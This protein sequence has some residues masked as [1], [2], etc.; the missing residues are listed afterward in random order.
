M[1]ASR[2]L[3]RWHA[4]WASGCCRVPGAQGR[5]RKLVNRSLL[6]APDGDRVARYDKIHLFDVDLPTGERI[7]ESA[8]LCRR[9]L[10][11]RSSRLPWG[12]LGLTICY[13]VRFPSLYRRLP[14]RAQ[15]FFTVPS[16]FTV[17]TGEAHWHVLLQGARDRDR[18]YVLAPAQGGSMKAAARPMATA[19]SSRRGARSWRKPGRSRS[20]LVSIIDPERVATARRTDSG[21]AHGRS[22][23]LKGRQR[24][25]S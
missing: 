16:A 25:A 7:R 6:F 12:G 23:A 10:R 24:V 17:P 11:C 4:N 8:S 22:F 20:Y 14:R 18:R 3:P 5:R 2:D 9:R 21:L 15:N 1:R 19:S 13:D